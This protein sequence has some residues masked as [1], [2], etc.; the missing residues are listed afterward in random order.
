[1]IHINEKFKI[2]ETE[3]E[4]PD[5]RGATD[6]YLDI[7]TSNETEHL[8][9]DFKQYSGLYPYK[10][11]RIGSFAVTADDCPEVY[12]VPMRHSLG[13]NINVDV[14]IRWLKDHL[15]SVKR[16]CN[17]NVKFDAVFC[18]CEGIHIG[19]ELIDTLTLAKV[20]DSDRLGHGLKDLCRD[21][22]RIPMEE[23]IEIKITLKSMRTMNYMR[24][25]I[26]MMGKYACMDVFGNRELYKFLVRKRDPSLVDIW[27]LEN[28]LA[29]VLFDMETTGVRVDKTQIGEAKYYA[30][31][32]T[33]NT[34]ERLSD[35][36]G[37]EFTD[38]NKCLTEIILK[39]LEL[40]IL[41]TIKEKKAG[42][43][44]RDTGRPTFDKDAL[45][46]YAIH[47]KVVNSEEATRIINDLIEFRIEDQFI[48]LYCKPFEQLRDKNNLIHPRFN[49]L[50][51]TGRM[52]CSMPNIQ[53]QNKR[54]KVLVLPHEGY[55]FISDDYS[56]IE[57]R[58]IVHYIQDKDAIKAYN[59]D[60][61]TDFHKWV[62]ELIGTTDRAG[63]KTVSF[64][65]A[66]G[67]GKAGVTSQLAGNAD[68]IK[69][70][71]EI[72]NKQ[73]KEG[74]INESDKSKQ[75]EVMC[76]IRAS[77]LYDTYH[78]KLPGIKLTAHR[79]AGLCRRRGW[80]KTA[81]GRRRNLPKNLSYRAFNSVIQG[82]AGDIM[83]EAM[84]RLSPRYNYV[85][86][87]IGLKLVINVHDEIVSMVPEDRLLDKEVHKH[88]IGV[89]EN[90][91]VS[92]NVPIRVGLGV[93]KNNW[94]EASGDE[95]IRDSSG[96]IIG[97]K[98]V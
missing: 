88:I 24:V 51:R 59:D 87:G 65:A 61:N 9:K 38:S 67:Q 91:S 96:K 93:S 8:G 64:G 79:A 39:R 56:Q 69:D 42:G 10:G 32:S 46:L 90:P 86:K 27:E 30:M 22:L 23:E 73:V 2:I 53:Q 20:H 12:Y 50:V 49:P 48:G 43:G 62:M 63:A 31:C 21:W 40:P 71:N 37:Q 19:C 92:F 72:L 76:R 26:D 3:S 11:D 25:P 16:W 29:L 44:K 66:Y 75:F 83:K 34:I 55:G 58:L 57:F 60:P 14:C 97:G 77:D 6:L 68:V 85:S 41:S 13:N 94:A 84:I 18:H 82:T 36:L 1:M 95:T 81:Y 89:L 70:V 54:S 47:P 4:L 33:L 17:H 52:S 45:K 5:F 74:E 98:I 28:K 80:V 35:F 78:A 15:G 7:E